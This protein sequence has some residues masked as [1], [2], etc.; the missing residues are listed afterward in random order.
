MISIDEFKKSEIKIGLIL[1][2][3]RVPDTDKLLKLSVDF[4]ESTPRQIISGIALFIADP[5]TLVGLRCP[6]VTN[7][8]PRV[9]Q[10]LESQGM[11]L[12]AGGRDEI[13]FS[14]LTVSGDIPPGTKIS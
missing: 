3:Q 11:I 2:A 1:S 9:I 13:P 12:A 14:L 4:A 10:G 6:F 8:E 5:T 7:L